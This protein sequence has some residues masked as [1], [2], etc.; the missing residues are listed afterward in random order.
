MKKYFLVIVFL[1]SFFLL[2]CTTPSMNINT[3]D[4]DSIVDLGTLEAKITELSQAIQ[5]GTIEEELAQKTIEK[6]QQKYVDLKGTTSTA[7]EDKF[8][9][10]KW[11]FVTKH[12]DSY[13]LPLWAKELWMSEPRWMSLNTQASHQTYTTS[14]W[15]D[16]TILVYQWDYYFALEEAKR[17]ADQAGL[18]VSNDFAQGQALA[19]NTNT[20]YI[21]WLDIDGLTQWIVYVNHELLETNVDN[22][23]SVSV[24]KNGTLIIET[25]QY[26]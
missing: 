25:I 11:L 16:S 20:N 13:V 19:Q 21:S 9:T 1:L 2:W 18:F 8:A 17:I 7:I 6:L 26:K 10:I 22:L 15:Y 23:L 24:D 3:L 14:E 5:D 4:V 12:V